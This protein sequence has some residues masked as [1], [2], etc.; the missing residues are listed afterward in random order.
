MGSRSVRVLPP[1]E[2]DQ[3][4]PASGPSSVREL[5]H[6]LRQPVAT[7]SMLVSAAETEGRDQIPDA[8]RGRLQ[9]I[10]EQSRRLSEIIR[11][12]LE[13]SLGFEPVD[14]G[15]AAREV[16]DWTRITYRGRLDFT[17]EMGDLRVIADR[18]L[19]RRGLANLLENAT[20]AA[21][22]GGNIAVAVGR[23]DGSV[24]V[25]VS[26]SGSSD[27]PP[28]G[29][30]LGLRIVERL[31]TTH[32]GELVFRRAPLG[33]VLARLTLPATKPKAS[34]SAEKGPSRV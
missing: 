33:G 3:A 30:G 7:I 15:R 31:A 25:D 8:L 14:V 21:G 12:V 24:I 5:C 10:A 23:R 22:D 32:G 6:D 29:T 13:E 19:L 11:H 16:V 27:S 2:P 4:A 9:L 28:L 18:V 1:V 17:L 26:D 34:A 20:R